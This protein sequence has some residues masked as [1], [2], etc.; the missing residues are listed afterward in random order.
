MELT[1][2]QRPTTSHVENF[3]RRYFRNGSSDPLHFGVGGSS[4][5]IFPIW[6][7]CDKTGQMDRLADGVQRPPREDHTVNIIGTNIRGRITGKCSGHKNLKLT[8]LVVTY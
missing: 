4:G 8:H 3:E 7:K 1:T 2:D 5:A 6:S